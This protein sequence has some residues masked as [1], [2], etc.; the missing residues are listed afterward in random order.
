MHLFFVVRWEMESFRALAFSGKSPRYKLW[1]FLALVILILVGCGVVW[2]SAFAREVVGGAAG[3][4]SAPDAAVFQKPLATDQLTFINDFAGRSSRDAA[5]DGRYKKLIHT[6][7]PDAPY[8]YHRDM[9][10]SE[11]LE[12]VL[13]NAPLPVAIRDGRYAMVASEAERG[14]GGLGFLWT[15]MHDGI[16]LGGFSFHPTNG[17]PTPTPTLTLTIF[18]KQIKDESLELN[19][20]PAAF[21]EDMYRWSAATGVPPVITRYFINSAGIKIVLEHDEDYCVHP[22]GSP[23]PPADVCD[24]MNEDAANV[25][26][27]AA[28]FMERT[29]YASNAT[30]RTA[31][32]S[33]QIVWI[34]LRDE[35]CKEGPERLRC[36]IRMTHERTRVLIGRRHAPGPVGP[37]RPRR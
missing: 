32:E 16:A 30:A 18:S 15:D 7:V 22:D 19:Q 10:I 13:T 11:A 24:Q 27:E 4:P 23:A 31:V 2:S 12:T 3:F 36:R 5:K 34:R 37:A 14:A 17:E 1:N 35:T 21:A 26:M 28:Y 9:P 6:V 25:D 8:H 33:D 29:G 20:L